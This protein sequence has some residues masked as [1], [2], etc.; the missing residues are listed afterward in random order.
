V[1]YASTFLAAGF[2]VSD[3]W[4]RMRHGGKVHDVSIEIPDL[5][6][7]EIHMGT[8]P[9]SETGNALRRTDTSVQSS[10]CPTFLCD[11]L[12]ISRSQKTLYTWHPSYPPL[13]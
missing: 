6:P 2:I 3:Q 12:G 4:S 5:R 10:A 13:T 7:G 9:F 8:V 1:G 11:Q